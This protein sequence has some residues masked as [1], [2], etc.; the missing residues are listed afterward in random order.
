MSVEWLYDV[1]GPVKQSAIDTGVRRQ[2]I[3]TKP[4]GALG[5]LE[6]VAINLCG[7]L[8]ET[9]NVDEL[10]IV[11]FAGDHG[12]AEEGVS[13]FPQVVTGEMI[14][15]FAS[16]G[17]A[18][19]VLA[20]ELNARLEVVNM[21]TVNDPGDLPGVVN[22]GI[23]PSSNNL[24]K[25]PAMT[26]EQL[27]RALNAGRDAALRAVARKANL[28]IG[29]DMGIANT[30]SATAL[31]CAYMG[32]TADDL[33]GPGTGLDAEGVAHKASV[34]DQALSRHRSVFL[35][36]LTCCDAWVGSK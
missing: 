5:R 2:A 32:L 16:G 15:N 19:C 22:I 25:A 9:P 1:I 13:A 17:A 8:G 28:F 29:G 35:T 34:I 6:Q 30:T 33:V 18:I 7:L 23:A 31:G 24:C 27:N 20:R 10:S 11:V 21:G 36:P 14:K 4:P 26:N 12:V 3:L